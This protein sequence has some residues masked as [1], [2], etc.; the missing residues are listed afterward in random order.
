MAVCTEQVSDIVND[1]KQLVF[2]Q[3]GDIVHEEC[4]K[5]ASRRNTRRWVYITKEDLHASFSLGDHLFHQQNGYIAHCFAQ[6]SSLPFILNH[7]NTVG[8]NLKCSDMTLASD[9]RARSPQFHS[10]PPPSWTSF[11][12]QDFSWCT[13]PRGSAFCTPGIC[14]Q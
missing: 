11:Q 4:L 2:D 10:S 14:N 1:H 7:L 8:R 9:A 12:F 3:K 6:S 5:I 13:L